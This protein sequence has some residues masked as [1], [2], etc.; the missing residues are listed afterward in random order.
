MDRDDLAFAGVA[1]QAELVRSGEVSSRELVMLYLERIERLDPQLNAFRRVFSERALVDAQQ[2]DGRRGAGDVR[3]LLGVPMAVKDVEDVTGDVT[4]WGTAAQETP[5]AADSELVRRLRAAGAVPIGK[6]NCPEL[7][8]MGDTEGPA[9]GITR[10]PWDP[11]RSA[12]GS[13]GGSAAAVAAGLCAAATASDG[14]GSI[15]IPAANCGL[16]GLKPTRDRIPLAPLKEHWYGLS[17]AGFEARSTEDVAL[18]MSV[19]TGDEALRESAVA[20]RE[21]LRVAVSTKPVVPARVHPDVKR[22]VE[23]VAGRLGSLGHHVERDD[24][25]YPQVSPAFVRYL[26]GFAQ[27]AE[28]RIERPE[29]L[30]RRTKGFARMGS[31]IPR[32]VLDWARREDDSARYRPFFDRHDVL[33]TAVNAVPC[34]RAGQWEGLGAVRTLL[35]MA[36][37]H[38]FCLEWNLT[39]NPAISVPTGTGSDGLPIGVMIVA[40][41]GEEAT[42]LGLAAQLEAELRWTDRRPPVS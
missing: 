14:A 20:P 28:E 10:N 38:P 22:A 35:G 26:A 8:I 31:A 6:T 36:L 39:G 17:V 19:G 33:V 11:D 30:Q 32:P 24:P 12:G 29:R 23:D 5:A 7:A 2:A 15:R 37:A 3:P 16:V 25:P 18:L 1:R 41:H 4:R 21:P 13:S 42:L 34:T 9:F 40:R 27:D